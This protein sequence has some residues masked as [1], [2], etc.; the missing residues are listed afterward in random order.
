MCFSAYVN[1]VNCQL[2]ILASVSTCI[3]L[4]SIRFMLFSPPA[5]SWHSYWCG[6]SVNLIGNLSLYFFPNWSFF[7]HIRSLV[8]FITHAASQTDVLVAY[9]RANL[10]RKEK[11]LEMG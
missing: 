4:A 8:C 11:D 3:S 10:R 1:S 5:L 2:V 7:N 6:C 9:S